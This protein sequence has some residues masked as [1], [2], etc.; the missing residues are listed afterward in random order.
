MTIVESRLLCMEIRSGLG[1]FR[2]ILLEIADDVAQELDHPL[3]LRA[4]RR[5]PLVA[6]G[7]P[8]RDLELET[9]ERGRV[10]VGVELAHVLVRQDVPVVFG[11]DRH[12]G[13]FRRTAGTP[14]GHRIADLPQVWRD[15]PFFPF[16]LV[17]VPLVAAPDLH[18]GVA[19]A[20]MFLERIVGNGGIAARTPSRSR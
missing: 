10:I 16:A 20:L 6:A 8:V 12:S 2:A 19:L 11:V 1:W 7:A 17:V 9:G 5:A 15:F 18:P 3:A 4:R 14:L 13:S